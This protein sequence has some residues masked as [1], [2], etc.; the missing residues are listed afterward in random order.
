MY[1]ADLD[2]RSCP[3]IH[4]SC[5]FI[6]CESQAWRSEAQSTVDRAAQEKAISAPSAEGSGQTH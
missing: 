6:A 1:R 5:V 4:F 2:S 3:S